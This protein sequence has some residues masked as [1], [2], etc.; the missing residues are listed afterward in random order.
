MNDNERLFLAFDFLKKNGA[1]KT[2]TQ[3]AQVLGTNKAGINDL[4]VGK[5]KV[6]IDNIRNMIKSYP[7]LSLTWLILEEGDMET[8]PL[9]EITK[10]FDISTELLIMQ[11]EK[12][13][14]LQKEINDLKKKTFIMR[15][16]PDTAK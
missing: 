1:I 13:E 15:N 3:L 5:K 10:G 2:Y 4:K 8:L 6:S 16:E 11:K 9:P 7:K 12:I 14:A